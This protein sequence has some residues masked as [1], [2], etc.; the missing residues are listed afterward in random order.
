MPPRSKSKRAGTGRAGTYK[1]ELKT[2]FEHEKLILREA[3]ERFEGN[4]ANCAKAMGIA[5]STMYE[6]LYTHGLRRRV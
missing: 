6:K 3:M 5:K 2:L 1:Y 4:V